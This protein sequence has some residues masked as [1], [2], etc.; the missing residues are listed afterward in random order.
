MEEEEIKKKIEKKINRLNDKEFKDQFELDELRDA[1]FNKLFFLGYTK[2]NKKRKKLFDDAKVLAKKIP[3]LKGWPSDSKIFWNVEA[4]GWK[5]KIPYEVREFIKKEIKVNGKVLSLGS[6][7]YPYVKNSVLVDISKD[8][9]DLAK[10]K[11]KIV[12]DLNEKLP[13]K[14]NSFDSATL[15]FVIDYIKNITGL[16]KEV[17]RVLKKNGKLIIVQNKAVVDDYYRIQEKKHIVGD[18]LKK[19][20]KDFKIDYSEKD[21]LDK[22]L[23]FVEAKVY[24]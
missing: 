3:E 16:I 24:K 7:C 17:K 1:F 18:N 13:F 10:A 8:M 14:N 19:L 20:L 12:H 5:N 15:I 11:R 21:I 9:L 22:K 23:V 4:Y 6:G 2:D